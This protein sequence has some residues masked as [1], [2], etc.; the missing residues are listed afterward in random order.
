MNHKIGAIY[1]LLL[2]YQYG[3]WTIPLF[4]GH[5]VLKVVGKSPAEVEA[6]RA[7]LGSAAPS[8]P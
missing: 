3:T 2:K 1:Q 7:Q 5:L 8:A 6:A 4:K